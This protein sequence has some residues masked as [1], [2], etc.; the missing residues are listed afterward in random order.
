MQQDV[1][2]ATFMAIATSSP[3]F[4]IN[5]IGTF[6]TEGD[7][8]VSTIAGSAVFNCVAVPA[9]CG[10]FTHSA[11]QLEWW[12]VSR[13]CFFYGF[14]VIALIAVIY[15]GRIMW[16]EAAFLV[17]CYT[18]YLFCKSKT[19]ASANQCLID[20]SFQLCTKIKL[21]AR[22][23]SFWHERCRAASADRS[24]AR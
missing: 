1:A 19:F 23:R 13:D 12:S 6:V 8:G 15:D 7:I 4:V 11:I 20:N 2:A 14:S 10:L 16:Y 3:E 9:L 18:I 21:C 17:S 5:C 24:I 22:G